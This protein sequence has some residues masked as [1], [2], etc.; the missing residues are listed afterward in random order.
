[1]FG[2]SIVTLI[3]I[4][5]ALF[6]YRSTVKKSVLVADDIMN[7]VADAV[8]K[9]STLLS[10]QHEV[11]I[12]KRMLELEQEIEAENLDVEK[13]MATLQMRIDTNR[14]KRR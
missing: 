4:C 8:E 10:M 3:V 6:Y 2:F 9:E 13:A 5:F 14:K 1:M 11:S 7:N 12:A